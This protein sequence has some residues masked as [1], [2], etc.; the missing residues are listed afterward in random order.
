LRDGAHFC[1]AAQDVLDLLAPLAARGATRYDL[2]FEPDA[3][4]FHDSLWDEMDGLDLSAPAYAPPAESKFIHEDE[5]SA[6]PLEP[7]RQRVEALLGPAPLGMD[8]LARASACSIGEIRL[9]LQ[10]LEIEGRIER[11]GGDR[12]SLIDREWRR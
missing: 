5:G 3:S 8:D 12:V 9:I 11:H 1:T 7:P 10:E 4:P 2:L 6:L